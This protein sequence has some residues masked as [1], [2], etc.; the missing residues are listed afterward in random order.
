MLALTALAHLGDTRAQAPAVHRHNPC[1]PQHTAAVVGPNLGAHLLAPGPITVTA[2]TS[3]TRRVHPTSLAKCPSSSLP[4]NLMLRITGLKLGHCWWSERWALRI[5]A[6][7]PVLPP[8]P[9][10]IPGSR[11][12]SLPRVGTFPEGLTAALA[13]PPA[14]LLLGGLLSSAAELVASL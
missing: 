1:T 7:I 12:L 14:Q 5:S 11:W 2:A 13:L 3:T 6:A 4:S 10:P 9:E 8:Q